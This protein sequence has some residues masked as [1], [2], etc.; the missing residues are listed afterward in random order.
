MSL[1]REYERVT[2]FLLR[3]HTQFCFDGCPNMSFYCLVLL[4]TLLFLTL[5]A[6]L[7][8]GFLGFVRLVSTFLALRFS[9]R[10]LKRRKVETE[11]RA[12]QLALALVGQQPF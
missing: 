8:G 11:I 2:R 5:L 6:A 4:F 3:L 1:V 9:F 10:I 7:L 12:W